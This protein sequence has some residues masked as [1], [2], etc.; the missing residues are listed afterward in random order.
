MTAVCHSWLSAP[1]ILDVSEFWG[2]SAGVLA[3]T[4]S[5]MLVRQG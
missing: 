1:G 4:W 5:M 2:V 3:S